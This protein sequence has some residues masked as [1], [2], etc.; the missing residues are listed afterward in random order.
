[1]RRSSGLTTV[2]LAAPATA[3]AADGRAVGSA[4]A[5][6]AHLPTVPCSPRKALAG[7]TGNNGRGEFLENETIKAGPDEWV[8]LGRGACC[9][10]AGMARA[11]VDAAAVSPI[12]DTPFNE[13]KGRRGR[14][15]SR[16]R[17]GSS[18][19]GEPLRTAPRGAEGKE[20]PAKGQGR[21]ECQVELYSTTTAAPLL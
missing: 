16:E 20:C 8:D 1:M 10:E 12:I 15:G 11:V 13:R 3:P 9:S 19:A 7:G 14:E 21:V 2:R 5:S 17:G 4:R 6:V 18:N